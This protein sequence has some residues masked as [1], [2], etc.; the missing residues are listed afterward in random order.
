MTVPTATRSN[1]HGISTQRNKAM[2]RS[3]FTN[4]FVSIALIGLSLI[5]C[6]APATPTTIP[7]PIVVT[8]SVTSTH[9]PV[10]TSVPTNTPTTTP[11][12]R[13]QTTLKQ[14]TTLYA[15]PGNE[16]YEVL[17]QL[18]AETPVYPLGIFVDFVK[19]EVET[20]GKKEG[21]LWKESLKVLPSGLKQLNTKDVP[22]QPVFILNNFVDSQTIFKGND[23]ILQ[24]NSASSY[25][26][27]GLPPISIDAP[28]M[29]TVKLQVSGATFGSIK[30]YGIYKSV[31]KLW[32]C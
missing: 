26:V 7:L 8:P 10:A 29:L 9:T 22:W 6:T 15:G 21:Y 11:T 23:V 19:V 1:L 13:P 2:N 20:G 16:G 25:D 30:T 12:P 27:D 32:W 14:D 5:G 4:A 17:A 28:F 31:D 3:M 18:K 24:N